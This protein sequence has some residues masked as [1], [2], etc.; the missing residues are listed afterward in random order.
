MSTQRQAPQMR[1]DQREKLRAGQATLKQGDIEG[2][3]EILIELLEADPD[4]AAGHVGLGQ[5]FATEGDHVR[6]LEHFQEAIAI[7]PGFARAYMLSAAAHEQLGDIDAALADF[8]AAIE[9][10]PSRGFN[11][12]RKA[13]LLLRQ[14]RGDEAQAVLEEGVRRNPQ[15]PTLRT[16]LAGAKRSSAMPKASCRNCS[17]RSRWTRRTGFPISRWARR[18]CARVPSRPPATASAARP[19]LNRQGPGAPGAGRGPGQA[20]RSQERGAR[21]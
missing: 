6:A 4:L 11:Y 10:N 5:V 17:A 13:Q 12:V 1:P 2:A 8:D 14:N 18:I 3:R 7:E 20:G 15:D 21:L 9:A 16:I 19:T